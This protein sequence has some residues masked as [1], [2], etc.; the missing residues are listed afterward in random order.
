MDGKFR[1]CCDGDMVDFGP[2]K[3]IGYLSLCISRPFS[4]AE[5]AERNWA[6]PLREGTVGF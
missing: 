3:K 2:I 6:L 5:H 1:L 4:F